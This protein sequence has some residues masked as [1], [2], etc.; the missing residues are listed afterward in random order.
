MAC[1][2]LITADIANCQAM[3]RQQ[4]LEDRCISGPPLPLCKDPQWS[5]QSTE[6]PALDLE[7]FSDAFDAASVAECGMDMDQVLA[8][9]D[10]DV[11]QDAAL[12][13]QLQ[14]DEDDEVSEAELD[15]ACVH[16]SLLAR[17]IACIRRAATTNDA[18]EEEEGEAEICQRIRLAARRLALGREADEDGEV[19]DAEVE[20]AA[21]R[22]GMLAR[23]YALRDGK[24][25]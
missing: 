2:L 18:S 16:M 24:S 10:S 15:Q 14:R 17:Q 20:A 7:S 19:S 23:S 13:F 8:F 4:S 25:R 12:A 6:V 22:M 1:E 11:S 3:T 21:Y 9:R 5:R